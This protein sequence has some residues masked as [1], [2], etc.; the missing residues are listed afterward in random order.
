M[1]ESQANGS[2][3]EA[4]IGVDVGGTHTDVS[5]VLRRPRRARQGAD[6]LRRLQPRRA[7]GRRASPPKELRPW[8]WRSCSS[9]DQL[10]MNGTTV[11]TNTITPAARL[12]RRRPRHQRLPRRVPPRRRPAHDRDRRPPAAQRPGPRRPPRDRRDRRAHRLVRAPSSC[13]STSRQVKTQAKY[14]VEEIGVDALAVCFLWSHANAE[15]ELDAEK[16]I[17]EL[18]PDIFVT[19]SHRVFPVE[20]ETRRWTTAVLNSFVQDRADDL[21]RRR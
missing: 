8:R 19:P 14:L 4:F 18:Y 12:A 1:T 9:H 21:P 3:H 16:A 6:D 10:F 5:V 2:G 17:K 13:R 15:H 20:G 11:V 7:R